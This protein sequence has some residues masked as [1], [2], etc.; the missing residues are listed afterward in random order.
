[1]GIVQMAWCCPCGATELHARGL[2][3]RCYDA[4]LR[5]QRRFG[6]QREAVIRRDGE[7]CLICSTPEQ[8]IVHHRSKKVFATL[9]RGD[10]A[11]VHHLRRLRWG[12]NEFLRQLWREQHSKQPE[13][14]ELSLEAPPAPPE[15][16]PLIVLA[17]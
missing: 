6:G 2:C 11:R 12:M 17:A 7:R 14:L 15:Q 8:V 4:W 1:V 3:L 10:H 5:S 9:C 16:L 13:Q